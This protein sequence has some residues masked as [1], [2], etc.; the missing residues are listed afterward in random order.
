MESNSNVK[1]CIFCGNS[2][3]LINRAGK[4]ICRACISSLVDE[5]G[6][7]A[8][9]T[10]FAEE[11]VYCKLHPDQLLEIYCMHCGKCV[12]A[13]CYNNRHKGHITVSLA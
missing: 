11:N 4:M 2:V 5:T 8:N 12:C 1:M 3:D 10:S 9:E 13:D 6:I 7:K